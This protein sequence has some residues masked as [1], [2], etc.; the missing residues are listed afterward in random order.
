M[1]AITAVIVFGAV[2]MARRHAALAPQHAA[3]SALRR[4]TGTFALRR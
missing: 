2:A 1:T 3:M 4:R